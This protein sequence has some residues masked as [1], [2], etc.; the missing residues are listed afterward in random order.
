KGYLSKPKTMGVKIDMSS[1]KKKGDDYDTKEYYQETKMWAGVLNN[2]ER[3]CRN[4]K[5]ILFSSNIQSSKDVCKEFVDRGYDA[6]HLDGE[7][8]K[9]ERKKILDWFDKTKNGIICN[10]GIL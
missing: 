5:T 1:M 6:K 2:W 3:L 9:N 10:C 7:T 4:T 8:P